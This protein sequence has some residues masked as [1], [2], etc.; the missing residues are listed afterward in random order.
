MRLYCG[1]PRGS[2]SAL[3]LRLGAGRSLGAIGFKGMGFDKLGFDRAT[4]DALLALL[5]VKLDHE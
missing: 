5:F 2:P 4:V 1:L 3:L